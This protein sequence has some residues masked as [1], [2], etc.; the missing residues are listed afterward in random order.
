MRTLKTTANILLL[1]F[2]TLVFVYYNYVLLGLDNWTLPK[3]TV[4]FGLDFLAGFFILVFYLH[5]KQIK[6]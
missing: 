2:F 3:F 5:I 4:L 1:T 6:I